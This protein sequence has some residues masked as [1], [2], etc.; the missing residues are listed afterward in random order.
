MP[1]DRTASTEV[2][3]ETRRST[4]DLILVGVLMIAVS[5]VIPEGPVAGYFK[6]LKSLGL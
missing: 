3:R 1:T 2:A 6:E 4:V 5:V